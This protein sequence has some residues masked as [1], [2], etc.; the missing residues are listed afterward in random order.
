MPTAS[1]EIVYTAESQLRRPGQFVRDMM[2]DLVASRELAWRL[3]VRDIRAQYRRSLLGYLWV[4]LPPLV[5]TLVWV[6]LNELQILNVGETDVAYPAY[7]MVGTLLWREFVDAV[8]SPMRQLSAS[9]SVLTKL[10][11]PWEALIIAGIG[12]VLFNSSIRLVLVMAT[13]VVF[14]LRVPATILV[15]PL[16]MVAL[17]ALGGALGVLLVPFGLLYQDVQRGLGLVTS[18]WFYVTPIVYPVPTTWPAS[19]VAAVNP[20]TPLLV[21]T[22]EL[23]TTGSVSRLGPFALVCSLTLA[24][25][26]VGWVLNRLARPHLVQRLAA[27]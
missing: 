8:H 25:L 27:T 13:F 24:M 12:E 26:I 6:Y 23:M 19:L 22:R 7:V 15:A 18:L 1:A 16:G 4:L 17:V 21:T 3:L 11:F 2:S 10:S 9:R 14:R 20:V 5:T